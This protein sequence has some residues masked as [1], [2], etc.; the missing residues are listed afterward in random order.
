MRTVY[1][2]LLVVSAL[3]VAAC[4]ANK[5]AAAGTA[6]PAAPVATSSFTPVGNVKEIMKG[7]V[8]PSSK[9]IWDSVGT[10][11]GAK[12]LVERS[13]KTDEEWAKIESDALVLAEVAN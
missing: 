10:E 6:T 3:V 11:A 2:T 4:D 12:G 7:I 1:S 9:E 8:D 13:P 5:S